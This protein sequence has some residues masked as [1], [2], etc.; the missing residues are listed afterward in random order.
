MKNLLAFVLTTCYFTLSFAQLNEAANAPKNYLGELNGQHIYYTGLSHIRTNKIIF[1]QVEDSAVVQK[2][3]IRLPHDRFEQIFL[4]EN[5]LYAIVSD[6]EETTYSLVRFDKWFTEKARTEIMPYKDKPQNLDQKALS[7]AVNQ[8]T[9]FIYHSGKLLFYVSFNYV[10][11][12]VVD[13]QTMKAKTYEFDVPLATSFEPSD[14]LFFNETDA[15]VAFEYWGQ[16]LQTKSYYA[17]FVNGKSNAFRLNDYSNSRPA[18]ANASSF[19]FIRITDK[20]FLVSSAYKSGFDRKHLGFT[21]T[22]IEHPDITELKMQVVVN[23]RLNDPALWSKKNYKKWKKNAPG[24]LYRNTKLDEIHFI[25]GQLITS[26]R[27]DPEGNLLSNIFITSINMDNPKNPVINWNAVTHHG[28]FNGYDRWYNQYSHAYVLAQ[29]P[30][31]IRLFYN[32]ESSAINSDGSV[33]K[34]KKEANPSGAF[35]T[36]ETGIAILDIDLKDGSTRH[37]VSP[38]LNLAY[39]QRITSPFYFIANNNIHFILETY[40]PETMKEKASY[41]PKAV[42]FPIN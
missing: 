6:I 31:H 29:Y 38:Y 41:T 12:A 39:P 15:H 27:H 30:D 23:D 19:K 17:T 2:E 32:C 40:K 42:V 28:V 3:T 25:D 5:T 35:K 21:I 18:G 34:R 24:N 10:R 1:Y 14:A 26:L 36:V 4:F 33:K 7:K 13:F 20:D 8:R 11:T 16:S 9:K 22:E 37:I